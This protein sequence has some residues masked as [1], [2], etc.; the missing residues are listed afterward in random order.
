LLALP[1]SGR[2][3]DHVNI[4]VKQR[5]SFR[6]LAPVVPL[7]DLDTYFAGIEES[8]YM[9]F[10]A[11]VREEYRERLA[12]VTHIDGTARVQSVRSEDNPFLYGVLK[13]V[14]DHTGVPVL[15]NTSLNL[16]GEPIVER[17]SDALDLFIRRPIDALVLGDQ[18]VRKYTPWARSAHRGGKL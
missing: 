11:T 13:R 5:E 18:I 8:P 17:P 12:A 4:D 10:V 7:D 3:R 1:T 14:G 16:R 15:L 6:P 9:L 2:T